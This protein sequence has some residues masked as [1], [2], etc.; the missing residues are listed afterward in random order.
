MK[1]HLLVL[2]V[3]FAVGCKTTPQGINQTL[4]FTE[5][6]GM[7]AAKKAHDRGQYSDAI[8]LYTAELAKERAKAKPN[9]VQ[10]SHLNNKLGGTLDRAGQ[11][12]KGDFPDSFV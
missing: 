3:V 8:R 12:V 7:Q 1:S 10:L 6:P 11:F 2:A 4:I 5:T 9:W